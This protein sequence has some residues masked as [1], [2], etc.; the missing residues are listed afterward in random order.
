MGNGLALEKGWI[1]EWMDWEFVWSFELQAFTFLTTRIRLSN[2]RRPKFVE[3][4]VCLLFVFLLT[5]D[6]SSLHTPRTHVF[7]VLL[8][9]LISHQD[10][11]NY[12][13]IGP[14]LRHGTDHQ[15]CDL[16]H[17]AR[18]PCAVIGPQGEWR[19]LIGRYSPR[20]LAMAQS[21]W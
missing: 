21:K 8:H 12:C 3:I 17:Q 16:C 18:V 6:T 13:T 7:W 14:Q 19:P 5:K 1:L 11:W 10:F 9:Y 4:M 20:S 15:A 2:V